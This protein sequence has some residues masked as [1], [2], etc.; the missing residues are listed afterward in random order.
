MRDNNDTINYKKDFIYYRNI[1]FNYER[2]IINNL[3]YINIKSFMIN[4]YML[5]KI[6]YYLSLLNKPEKVLYN[7]HYYINYEGLEIINKYL[8]DDKIKNT[9]SSIINFII[10]SFDLL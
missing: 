1:R 3:K 2:L 10:T 5:K 7:N 4:K 6:N 9:C 8:L